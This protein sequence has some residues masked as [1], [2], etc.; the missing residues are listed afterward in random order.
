MFNLCILTLI[1][2][3][4][5]R[6]SHTVALRQATEG[7]IF[8]Q[9]AVLQVDDRLADLVVLGQHVVVVQHHAE[10]LLQREGTVEL[11]QPEKKPGRDDAKLQPFALIFRSDLRSFR[12]LGH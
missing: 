3:P 5:A 1:Y 11:K 6:Y 8:G 9:E 10:V 4:G 2:A 12:S 7:S